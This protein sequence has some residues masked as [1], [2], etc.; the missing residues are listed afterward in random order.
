MLGSEQASV[1]DHRSCYI[2][3]RSCRICDLSRLGESQ[4]VCYSS[5]TLTIALGA[6]VYRLVAE[7]VE[8]RTTRWENAA[9][10]L[11]FAACK[12]GQARS[13]TGYHL[14]ARLV[15]LVSYKN[16]FV[17]AEANRNIP[18]NRLDTPVDVSVIPVFYWILLRSTV[19]ANASLTLR[20]LNG[21]LL[22]F[23]VVICVSM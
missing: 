6:R 21:D 14:R 16:Q 19:W 1:T 20:T 7:P 22:P 3:L 5:S 9:D 4:R 18:V 2:Q 15:R 8:I 13:L 10:L 12:L 11:R 23:I 17:N